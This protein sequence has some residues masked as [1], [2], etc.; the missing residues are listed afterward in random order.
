MKNPLH[1]RVLFEAGLSPC[2]IFIGF[3]SSSFRVYTYVTRKYRVFWICVFTFAERV[4]FERWL[5]SR[6]S[7][8]R[9]RRS[10]LI[11][12]TIFGRKFEEAT[13]SFI[14]PD[15]GTRYL[16][17]PIGRHDN[18]KLQPRGRT[19]DSWLRKSIRHND[20]KYISL[21]KG[22]DAR[23]LERL[24]NK[25]RMHDYLDRGDD[26]IDRAPVYLAYRYIVYSRPSGI[27][28][29]RAYVEITRS[30]TSK[31]FLI[32]D[33][34]RGYVLFTPASR[35]AYSCAGSSINHT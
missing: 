7:K 24:F 20:R 31:L 21:G 26:A 23:L 30:S 29:C 32:I 27:R 18:P 13:E 35:I 6:F 1:D 10:K 19:S 4:E 9:L 22:N 11:S 3:V 14:V 12:R 25:T 33:V 5:S 17:V 34:E 8:T 16:S 15:I 28:G 2:T